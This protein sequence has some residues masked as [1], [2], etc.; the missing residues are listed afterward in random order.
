[1]NLHALRTLLSPLIQDTEFAA[2]TYFAGGCVRDYLCLNRFG[3]SLTQPVKGDV[4]ITVEIEHGGIKLAEFLLPVLQG[5]DFQTFP[6]FGTAKMRYKNI[7]LEFVATRKEIYNNN[8]RYPKTSFGTLQDDVLRRDFTINALL[9]EIMTGEIIDLTGLGVSD[10]ENRIIRT[11]G[12]PLLKFREDP[13]RMLRALRFVLRFDYCI[14]AET[15]SAMV[16][17]AKNINRLSKTSI[18]N[19]FAK[20]L[21]CNSLIDIQQEIIALGWDDCPKLQFFDHSV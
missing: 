5:S 16:I 8:S 2:K 1:L 19:E 4:D 7:V 14:E 3:R 20:M 17:Q 15:H 13:L 18:R 21:S 9:M 12:D 10:L 11:V 6:E